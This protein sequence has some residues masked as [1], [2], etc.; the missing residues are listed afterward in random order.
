MR[1]QMAR[2]SDHNPAEIAAIQQAVARG[3]TDWITSRRL[4]A[5]ALATPS[6]HTLVES[7]ALDAMGRAAP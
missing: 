2:P 1:A 5:T 7:V 3:R 4:L 6:W